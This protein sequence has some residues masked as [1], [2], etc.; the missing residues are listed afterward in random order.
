VAI[1]ASLANGVSRPGD[2]VT[3][4]N[5]QADHE[6]TLKVLIES[7][8]RLEESGLVRRQELSRRP[9]RTHYWLTAFGYMLLKELDRLDAWYEASERYRAGAGRPSGGII[10]HV[11]RIYDYELGG[12]TNFQVDRDA[13]EAVRAVSPDVH[14]ASVTHRAFVQR[15]TRFLIAE[16]IRQ[17]LDIGSGLPTAGNVHEIAHQADPAAEVV[18][19]DHDPVVVA[20]GLALLEG[21]AHAAM[22]EADLCRPEEILDN[23]RVRSLIDFSR[24]AGLLVTGV[25]PFIPD[26]D[27][28]YP[29]VARL[30][31]A[32]APGSYLA[33]SHGLSGAVD[34]GLVEEGN[35]IYEG[36]SHA[37][38]QR[39]R[40]DI[41]RFLDGF[42][43]LGPG[44]VYAPEWRP[45]PGSGSG[46]SADD[47][48]SSH[49]EW[50]VCAVGCLP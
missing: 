48:R 7:L 23:M 41:R 31:D 19:F 45:V 21:T 24:P 9:R 46:D 50:T 28:P 17:F 42:E 43:I 6:L 35:R 8:R 27:N 22:I 2:L 26:K 44:L 47:T 25:L 34:P 12:T 16:G 29:A 4:I 38:T 18:Y 13:A 33:I 14:Y 37:V 32:A 10:P 20:H 39:S 3:A 40:D 5:A 15:I 36:S 49:V 1:L 30:R 11:A